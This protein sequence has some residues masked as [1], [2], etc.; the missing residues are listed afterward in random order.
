VV[1]CLYEPKTRMYL[2]TVVALG[3]VRS[4]LKFIVP[5]FDACGAAIIVA[6]DQAVKGRATHDGVSI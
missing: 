2:A 3:V 1:E 5:P 6:T 4:K